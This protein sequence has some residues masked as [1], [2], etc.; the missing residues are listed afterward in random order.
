MTVKGILIGIIPL[1]LL[2]ASSAGVDLAQGELSEI[3]EAISAVVISAGGALSAVV[4]LA[5]LV[6]KI[7]VKF[8]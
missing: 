8:R 2:I 3:V 5:G 4:T 6:R 1:V 7:A